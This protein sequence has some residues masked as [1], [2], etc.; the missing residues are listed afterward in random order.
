MQTRVK[1]VVATML[2]AIV[3]AGSLAAANAA[4]RGMADA[5]QVAAQ[6]AAQCIDDAA[7]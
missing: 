1:A 3:F 7:Q 6:R 2:L 5:Q 4:Q